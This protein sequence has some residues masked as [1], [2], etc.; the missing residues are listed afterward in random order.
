MSLDEGRDER[1][2][3]D[4]LEPLAA[5][6]LDR[7][8]CEVGAEAAAFARWVDLGVREGDPVAVLPAVVRGLADHPVAET[9]LVTRL[10]WDV[11]DNRVLRRGG[12]LPAFARAEVLNELAGRVRLAC[13]L[14]VEEAAAVRVG[15][16]PGLEL[17]EVPVDRASALE[18]EAVLGLEGRD[19]VGAG[20][21]AQAGT[22]LGPGLDLAR[23]EVEAE[24]GED[25]TDGGGERAPL[26]LIERQQRLA[27]EAVCLVRSVAERLVARASAP[28]ER[29]PLAL[30]ED[31]SVGVQNADTA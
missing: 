27:L 28:A 31:A 22:L 6:I 13:V 3:W 10:F 30:V 17:G 14:V 19:L 15:V 23:D 1:A 5:S 11:D 8:C 16:L 4:D 12:D 26:G 29:G 21:S 2:Q 25:L 20:E 24:L 18:E 7:G 9:E